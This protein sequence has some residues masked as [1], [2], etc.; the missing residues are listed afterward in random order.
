MYLGNTV[1]MMIFFIFRCHELIGNFP[2]FLVSLGIKQYGI[3][4]INLG[5]IFYVCICSDQ[6]LFNIQV[7]FYIH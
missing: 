6:V 7:L 2:T 5:A 1:Y 4:A 3:C